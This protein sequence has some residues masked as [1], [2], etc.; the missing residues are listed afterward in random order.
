[1]LALSLARSYSFAHWLSFLIPLCRLFYVGAREGHLPDSLSL[2][3]I[4]CY[5]PVPALLFNVSD[6]LGQPRLQTQAVLIPHLC[7][8]FLTGIFLK[9]PHCLKLLEGG[10]V[11]LSGGVFPSGKR[12][13]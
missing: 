4:K 7:P 13:A 6:S 9:C 8:V 5:T 2:I 3:H 10:G 11:I 12:M 1:M